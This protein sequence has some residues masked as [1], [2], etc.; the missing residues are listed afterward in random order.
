MIGAEVTKDLWYVYVLRGARDGQFYVGST[1]D[2]QRRMAE[3]FAGRNRSTARRLPVKLIYFEAH[4]SKSDALRREA[5]FKTTKGKVTL[6]QVLR[7]ALR[8]P[9]EILE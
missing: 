9:F 5:Y 3:H 4:L 7:D 6:R 8:E 1:N 2:V